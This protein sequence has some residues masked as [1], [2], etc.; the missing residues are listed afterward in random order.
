MTSKIP[1]SN[2]THTA[3]ISTYVIGFILSLVLTLTAFLIVSKH[4]IHGN[5]LIFSLAGL[6]L[7]QFLVQLVF[8][9]HMDSE[10]K[11]RWNLTALFFAVTV[12]V[13]LV[14]G[15]LW[16]MYHLNYNMTSQQTN[17]YIQQE[18]NIYK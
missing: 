10:P 9:L 14:A 4:G 7:I 13:I 11:P 2:T 8:F 16:I 17:T 6:A 3:T 15:S 12:I 1:S 5:A 18:E